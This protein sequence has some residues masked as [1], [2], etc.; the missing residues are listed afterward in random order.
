ML[1]LVKRPNTPTDVWR[2]SVQLRE[3][4]TD[5]RCRD[6]ILCLKGPRPLSIVMSTVVLRIQSNLDI[7]KAPNVTP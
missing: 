3:L 4:P 7:T 6:K 5:Y 2:M 1:E